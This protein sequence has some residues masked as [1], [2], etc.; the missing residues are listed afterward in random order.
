MN[1]KEG[2]IAVTA[3]APVS[4]VE[5]IKFTSDHLR[6]TIAEELAGDAPAFSSDSY[7]LLKFHGIYQQDDRDVRA[8]RKRQGLDVDHI[9]MVRVSI[10]GGILNAEQ[11]LPMDKLCDAVGNGTLRITSRQGIQYHFVRKGDLTSLLSLSTTT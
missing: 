4:K 5:G 10:P 6:G 9:C 1:G 11:Y 2:T 3:D 8:E 7:E